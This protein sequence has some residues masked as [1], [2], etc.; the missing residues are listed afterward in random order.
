MKSA[1]NE[2][3]E[4]TRE[5]VADGYLARKLDEWS[6]FSAEGAR[7]VWAQQEANA[8]SQ[9]Y[10]RILAVFFLLALGLAWL[11]WRGYRLKRIA[12]GAQASLREA[13]RRFTA[14]MENSPAMSFMKDS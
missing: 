10:R 1:A 6:S 8:R 11:A 14:F 4:G 12:E 3:R 13:Q 7:S 9:I 5:L 2:L